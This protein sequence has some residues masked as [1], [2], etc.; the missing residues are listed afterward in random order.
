MYYIY[1]LRCSDNSLYTGITNDFQ[2]RL[3]THKR[4]DK[5]AAK[6]TRSRHVTSVAALWKTD[7]K[8]SALKLEARIKR[9]TKARKENLISDP[10]SVCKYFADLEDVFETI[11]YNDADAI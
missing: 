2:K 4:R 8:S 11:D 5:A 7:T 1:V 3:T 6:Y 9:L 10:S